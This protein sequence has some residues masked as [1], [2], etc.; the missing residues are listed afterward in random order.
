MDGIHVRRW[1]V[2][3]GSHRP[4]LLA[5]ASRTRILAAGCGE[6]A[7]GMI[8]THPDGARCWYYF[9]TTQVLA[10]DAVSAL[11][12]PESID[13]IYC[14]GMIVW[15]EIAP[16]QEHVSVLVASPTPTPIAGNRVVYAY[17]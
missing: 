2:V 14:H 17:P 5:R 9:P 7:L 13:A 12:Q 6:H 3:T 15:F 8:H 11:Q 1:Y 10:S 4:A 16:R